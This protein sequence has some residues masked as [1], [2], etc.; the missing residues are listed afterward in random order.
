MKKLSRIFLCMTLALSLVAVA[1]SCQPAESEDTTPS[2]T[3]EDI[4]FQFVDE[5][6]SAESQTVSETE[7]EADRNGS[8]TEAGANTE[9][10][11]GLIITPR[12][13][14]Q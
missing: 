1:V 5:S 8:P 6:G 10:G 11:F 7:T 2:D 9:G 12:P 3:V 13:R 4:T 14:K